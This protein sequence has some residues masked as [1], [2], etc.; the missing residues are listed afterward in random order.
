M[1]K[2]LWIAGLTLALAAGVFGTA[3]AQGNAP[4]PGPGMGGWH[5][6]GDGEGPLHDLMIEAA[7]GVLGLEPAEL[8]ACRAQG[9]TLLQI[10]LDE[11]MTAEAFRAEWTQARR[12]VMENAVQDGLLERDQVRRMLARR[13]HIR[14]EECP[15][16]GAFQGDPKSQ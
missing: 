10:A 13:A 1:K 5:S 15:A 16:F 6:Q 8:E 4:P 11:G 7:A 2:L 14:A 9:Q 12:A 3:Y